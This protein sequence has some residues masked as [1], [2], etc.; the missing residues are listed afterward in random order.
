MNPILEQLK[1]VD[2]TKAKTSYL[3]GALVGVQEKLGNG[4]RY[5][6]PL[7]PEWEK[8]C[9]RISDEIDRRIPIPEKGE[10]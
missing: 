8:L 7:D 4:L 10:S 1:D 6:V 2:V 9:V 3:I 5:K